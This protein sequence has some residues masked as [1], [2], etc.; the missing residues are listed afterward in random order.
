MENFWHMVLAALCGAG[1]GALRALWGFLRTWAVQTHP[2]KLKTYTSGGAN[3][4]PPG[5]IEEFDLSRV[6]ATALC[7]AIP[8]AVAGWKGV[9]LTSEVGLLAIVGGQL[10]VQEAVKGGIAL[11]RRWRSKP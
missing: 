1:L 7:G 11:W 8:G 3:S 2:D 6:V 4:P 10:G 5:L 9:P